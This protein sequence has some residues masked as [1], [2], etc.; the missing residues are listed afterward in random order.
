MVKETNEEIL[1]PHQQRH[2]LLGELAKKWHMSL[3]TLR[4]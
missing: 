4:P 1:E 3:R 2:Y